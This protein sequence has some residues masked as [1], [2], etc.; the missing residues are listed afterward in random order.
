MVDDR[1]ADS[2]DR[3]YL[4]VVRS[5]AEEFQVSR[6]DV[7]RI[8]VAALNDLRSRARIETFLSPLVMHRT[9]I[10]LYAIKRDIEASAKESASG[11]S[12]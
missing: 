2:T 8:Y 1:I 5:L 11:G 12:P 4:R 3:E 10:A 9:K 6:P 7:E